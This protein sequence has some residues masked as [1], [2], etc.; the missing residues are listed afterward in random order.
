MQQK[1]KLTTD[2][3]ERYENLSPQNKNIFNKVLLKRNGLIVEFNE[4]ITALLGCNT[5]VGV[6]GSEEQ[7]KS[8]LCYLL[9]YE[10]KPTSEITHKISLIKNA[11]RTVEKSSFSSAEDSR[12]KKELLC[13]SLIGSPKK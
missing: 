4:V 10:T 5:N 13:T 2:L 3:L 11:R 8:T 12:T 7:A 9:K 1:Q 6:L